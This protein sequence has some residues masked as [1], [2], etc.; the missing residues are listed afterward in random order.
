ME[1]GL[2]EGGNYAIM[3]DTDLLHAPRGG[4]SENHPFLD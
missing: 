3:C 2:S 4:R 1:D